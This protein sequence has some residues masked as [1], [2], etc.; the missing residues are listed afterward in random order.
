M[1]LPC[2]G[3]DPAV[4]IRRVREAAFLPETFF[5]CLEQRVRAASAC[6]RTSGTSRHRA[7]P[8]AA[9]GRRQGGDRRAARD[10]GADADRGRLGAAGH[11]PHLPARRGAPADEIEHAYRRHFAFELIDRFL[12]SATFSLRPIA[13]KSA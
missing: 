6:R 7:D 9:L 8:A 2:H 10:K 1:S 5:H 12:A 3:A 4:V 13:H 11:R